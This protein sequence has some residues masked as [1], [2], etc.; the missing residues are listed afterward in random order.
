MPEVSPE[1][2]EDC[3]KSGK[4]SWIH[5]G[6]RHNSDG[7]LTEVARR[8]KVGESFKMYQS[9]LKNRFNFQ[10]AAPNTPVSLEVEKVPRFADL[11]KVVPYADVIFVSKEV[12]LSQGQFESM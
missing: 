2:V 11:V 1:E 8:V 10:A 7:R 6:G 4:Y 9:R 3:V 5:L 12:A